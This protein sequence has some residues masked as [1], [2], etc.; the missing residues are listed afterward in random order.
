VA[1]QIADFMQTLS[2]GVYVVGVCNGERANAFT[3]SSV[4]PV[5][6]KP[7]VV[8]IAVGLDHA[9]RPLMHAGRAFTINV[10]KHDQMEMARHF[11]AVSGRQHDKLA[12]VHW[13]PGLSGAPILVD[14]LASIECELATVVPAGDHELVVGKVVDGAVLAREEQP[15]LYRDTCN[16]DGARDLYPPMLSRLAADSKPLR[17]EST[18]PPSPSSR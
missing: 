6:F 3:A 18:L 15:L 16:L 10:L 11:G 2:T 17:P 5:S 4:M 8:A 7:V 12:A 14:A 9:S 1:E 13:R